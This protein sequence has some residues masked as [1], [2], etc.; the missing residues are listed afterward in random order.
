MNESTNTGEWSF[1]F[2]TGSSLVYSNL[3]SLP[4][5]F[6]CGDAIGCR[7]IKSFFLVACFFR[8]CVFSPRLLW[9]TGISLSYMQVPT[10]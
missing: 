9:L 3:V 6:R 4:G 8:L 7:K 10:N 2:S 1:D 5:S